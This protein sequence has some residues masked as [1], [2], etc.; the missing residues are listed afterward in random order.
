[1]NEVL[2][3]QIKSLLE[4]EGLSVA[5]AEKK[6]DLPVGA[7]RNITSG[8]YTNPTIGTIISLV[9][10]FKCSA[11]F[12]L[13]NRSDSD[14]IIPGFVKKSNL[15]KPLNYD[16]LQSIITILKEE[17][18]ERKHPLDPD[19]FLRVLMEAY[20]YFLEKPENLNKEFVSLSIENK[21]S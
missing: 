12:L 17:D 4:K 14:K 7:I 8:R 19:L 16:L 18:T 6:A 1:M 13:F 3:N 21:T 20:F 5:A 11:D 10:F 15:E 9:E 2:K